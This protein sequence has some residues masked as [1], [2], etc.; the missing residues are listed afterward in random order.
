MEARAKVIDPADGSHEPSCPTNVACGTRPTFR[1]R[2]H[3]DC[4]W[5]HSGSEVRWT[6]LP[7]ADKIPF[8]AFSEG[9]DSHHG[10]R[11]LPTP[12]YDHSS[13]RRGWLKPNDGGRRGRHA[14]RAQ[15]LA[16]GF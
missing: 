16:K 3:H 8:I 2:S 14:R 5:T 4:L 15:G 1:P 12:P 11:T 9:I 7:A 10:R 6:P 13:L